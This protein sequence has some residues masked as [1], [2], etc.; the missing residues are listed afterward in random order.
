MTTELKNRSKELVK[1]IDSAI[2]KLRKDADLANETI[3]EL[4]SLKDDVVSVVEC[5][6]DCRIPIKESIQADVTVIEL[7]RHA[8]KIIDSAP[9][10]AD[11]SD[12]TKAFMKE[13]IG[14]H[15]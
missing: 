4:Q 14:D 9:D 12:M 10:E 1:R 5:F 7:A 11:R 15:S 3:G 13:F 6:D 2:K 8:R